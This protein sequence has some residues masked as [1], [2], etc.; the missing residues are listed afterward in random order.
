LD[1]DT[2]KL[3]DAKARFSEVVRRARAGGPQHVTVHGEEA[4]VIVDPKR[5]D[6]SPKAA[7]ASPP[8][9]TPA[10]AP[11]APPPKAVEPAQTK[12]PEPLPV[13]APEVVAREPETLAPRAHV[14]MPA[15]LIPKIER[16]PEPP[17]TPAPDAAALDLIAE[18]ELELRRLKEPLPEP[19]KRRF[20]DDGK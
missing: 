14:P 7:A 10:K 18:L 2:W 13:K 3:Q 15:P 4:V 5:F 11:E 9:I 8:E 16:V 12:A 6:I 1:T 19:P 17:P 20:A